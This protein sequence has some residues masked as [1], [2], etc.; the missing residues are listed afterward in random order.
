LGAQ[1][2][3]LVAPNGSLYVF[4]NGVND[5]TGAWGSIN[6]S[7]GAFTSLGNLATEFT[8]MSRA[9]FGAPVLGFNSSGSLLATGPV[10][11]NSVFGTYNLNNGNFQLTASVANQFPG[12]IPYD[13]PN[14]WNPGLVIAAIPSTLTA[15]GGP[16][17]V[18]GI[19]AMLTVPEPGVLS[20]TYLKPTTPAELQS[21]IGALAA[22]QIDFALAGST[23]QL[24]DLG[25]SG[26]LQGDATVTLHFDPS[27]LGSTLLSDLRVEHYENGLWVLPPNQVIDPVN[28]TI[29]FTTDG[30]SP[31]ALSTVPEPSSL[32]L[33]S[34]A[35]IGLLAHAWRRR[36]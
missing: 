16:T 19:G 34:I 8:W 9:G 26:I 4:D 25:F 24:W 6:A 33:L 28:D 29:T 13:T 30:F 2:N 7:T 15:G 12:F 22:G 17:S 18:G 35:T 10:G 32:I 14:G 23:P 31:F 21:A 20:S 27:L 11:N 1:P 3:L 5:A 36:K